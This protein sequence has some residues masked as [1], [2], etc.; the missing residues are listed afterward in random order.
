MKS[1]DNH[2]FPSILRAMIVKFRDAAR[3]N[4]PAVMPDVL[5]HVRKRLKPQP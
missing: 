5:R 4:A 3:R 2:E 1:D